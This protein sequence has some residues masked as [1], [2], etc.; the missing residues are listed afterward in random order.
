MVTKTSSNSIDDAKLRYA[1]GLTLRQYGW[2]M[3]ES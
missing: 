2:Y 1:N 3:Y